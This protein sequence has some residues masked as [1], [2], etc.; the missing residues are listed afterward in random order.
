MSEHM[1]NESGLFYFESPSMQGLYDSLEKWK[2]SS[3][4]QII[5]LSIQQDHDNFCCIVVAD[6]HDNDQPQFNQY[7]IDMAK[8][9]RKALK[10]IGVGVNFSTNAIKPKK[11]LSIQKKLEKCQSQEEVKAVFLEEY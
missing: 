4:A 8:F 10:Q 3:Q 5:S 7:E 2:N 6:S 11:I 9:Q 1:D